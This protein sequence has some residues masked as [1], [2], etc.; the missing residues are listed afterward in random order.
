MSFFSKL[1]TLSLIFILFSQFSLAATVSG[2]VYDFSLEPATNIILTVTTIP[3]QSFVSTDGYYSFSI[4]VGTYNI[5][6]EQY[7]YG[8]IIASTNETIQIIHD[9]D[10]TIDFI[11][12]PYVD[13]DDGLSNESGELYPDDET[14]NGFPKLI[15]LILVFFLVILIITTIYYFNIYT[16]KSNLNNKIKSAKINSNVTDRGAILETTN[17]VVSKTSTTG[18]RKIKELHDDIEKIFNFIRQEKHTTQK[19]IRDKF[20]EFS[21]AKVSLIITDLEDQKKVRKIK[22]GRGNVIVFNQ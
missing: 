5:T 21:E 15:Q 2:T 12:F 19:N 13:V 14:S 20:P 3:K 22:R 6:V 8:S 17:S 7:D 10:F 4:P 16:K 9:G 1:L 18:P 11:L